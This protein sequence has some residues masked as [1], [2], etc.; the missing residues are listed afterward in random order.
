MDR[1]SFLITNRYLLSEKF[2]NNPKINQIGI[3]P[4]WGGRLIYYKKHPNKPH[5]E[6]NYSNIN[7]SK[8]L[9]NL[10]DEDWNTIKTNIA[11]AKEYILL[12]LI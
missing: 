3:V 2:L 11:N 10:S 5:F 6:L 9:N 4:I 12:N 1:I 7:S 8:E